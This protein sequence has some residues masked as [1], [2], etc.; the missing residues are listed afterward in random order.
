MDSTCL[1]SVV[2][3]AS[4]CEPLLIPVNQVAFVVRSVEASWKLKPDGLYAV[5]SVT[6]CAWMAESGMFPSLSPGPYDGAGPWS[7]IMRTCRGLV[8]AKYAAD[9]HG[10]VPNE[11]HK[12]NRDHR[13]SGAH[14]G[15]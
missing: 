12:E 13:M 2:A 11:Q 8:E 15:P 10:M 3:S 5:F 6:I 14:P 9:R 1:S 4:A 7:A